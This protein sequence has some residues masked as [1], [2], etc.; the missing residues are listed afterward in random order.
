MAISRLADER[1]DHREH[2]VAPPASVGAVAPERSSP[3]LRRPQPPVVGRT[4]A[5]G[6]ILAGPRPDRAP[7][8]HRQPRRQVRRQCRL[9]RGTESRVTAS[10]P[11]QKESSRAL[12]PPRSSSLGCGRRLAL[13]VGVGI[14]GLASADPTT[15]AV[16]DPSR[17]R[18][19]PT[20]VTAARPRRAPRRSRSR[21]RRR[22]T[23][24]SSSPRSW[25]ST[26][27]KVTEALKEIRDA[28]PPGQ[29]VHTRPSADSEQQAHP[30]GPGDSARRRWPRPSPRSSASTRPR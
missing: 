18:A 29:A 8:S 11:F 25:G 24:P 26:E 10:W 13:G 21:C 5:L 14:A 2:A 23:W 28:E 20:R 16:A 1:D 30:A 6:L 9:S 22:P 15:T 7:H 3:D 19:R 17:L 27:A 4:A 12:V